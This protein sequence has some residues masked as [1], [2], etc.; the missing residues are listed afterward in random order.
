MLKVFLVEDEA[1][2]REGLRDKI[3]W[4]EYGYQFVGE[5]SDGEM[6]LPLI[7]KTRPDVLITDIKMP[8][9]D[10]L[11]L[12]KMVLEEFPQTRVVIISGYDDF[13]YARQA[14]A[15]GVEEYLLKPITRNSLTKVLTQIRTK[16]DQ[17]KEQEDY[18]SRYLEEKHEYE[19]FALRRF[20]EQVFQGKHSVQ[21]IY[22]EA[23]KLG[24]SLDATAYNLLFF[25]LEEK[26]TRLSEEVMDEFARIQDRILHFFLRNPGYFL[27][28]WNVDSFGVWI[29]G[30]DSNIERLTS[31]GVEHIISVCRDHE[32]MVW[33]VAQSE[34][35]T[36]LSQMPECYQMVNHFFSSRFLWP[37]QHVLSRQTL[38][39]YE[40]GDQD[41]SLNSV[42]PSQMDPE[43]IREFLKRGRPEEIRGFADSYFSSMSSALKSTMFRGYMTLKIRYTTI[44]YAENCGIS[45]EEFLADFGDDGREMY[46]QPDEVKEY[47]IRAASTVMRLCQRNSDAQSGR[48][49]KKA[50][51]Y[52]REHFAGEDLSLN[53]VAGYVG[54]S[55]NYL[56]TI[57]SQNM[58][59][60]FV[61]YVTSQR[62]DCARKLLA[63]TDLSSGEIAGRVGYK[64][65]H[66]F[67]FVFKKT[68]GVSPR[69]YRSKH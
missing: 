35:V 15:L 36:R 51:E 25:S 17:A 10:G 11:S 14:I 37:G 57:F 31:A 34:P 30:D 64:D 8:F 41:Q 69:E 20:M 54:V 22:E 29:M 48:I 49:L 2:I 23:G 61:E 13:G 65:S 66:Y 32:R 4:Q 28:R 33:Y 39:Q 9:M 67:S 47:F 27:F 55:A 59:Q 45:Q 21:E 60:T 46:L 42:D 38:E 50:Q 62:M 43:I 58:E 12:S 63:T 3:D 68:Q 53:K 24:I 1:V 16:L 19:Q 5:A 6:A 56:S 26:N 18:Q 40:A 44:A 7:R 52:I